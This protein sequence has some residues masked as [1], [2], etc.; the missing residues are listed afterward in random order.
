MPGYTYDDLRI[1]YCRTLVFEMSQDYDP[2]GTDGTYTHFVIKVRGFLSYG[3][4]PTADSAV[5]VSQIKS[6]LEA[7]RRPFT[8]RI[9]STVVVSVPNPPDAKLGPKP[10]PATVTAVNSGLFYV[11]C[12]CEVWQVGCDN[13]CDTRDPVVSLRWTQTESFDQN[14]YS[15][16]RT[17]GLLIVRADLRQCA[18]NFRPLA[19]PP[20]LPDYQR[21][22]SE[23]TLSPDGL[24]LEFSFDDQEVDRLPPDLATKAQGQYSVELIRPGYRRIGT[25][26]ISLE[27]PK[28]TSRKDLL[29]RA[30]LMA[31]T[32]LAQDKP[33][34]D[35]NAMWWGRFDEDL[36]S[37]KVRVSVSANMTPLNT[38]AT[39]VEAL[40]SV[41]PSVGVESNDLKSNKRGITPPER[42]RLARLLAAAFRDPC[43]C[44][45]AEVSLVSTGSPGAGA[46]NP[47]IVDPEPAGSAEL[48]TGTGFSLTAGVIDAA[49]S[50]VQGVIDTA[51]YD[52]MSIE[53]TTVL[54]TGDVMMP[55]TG[56]GPNADVAKPVKVAGAMSRMLV[57]W[58]MGR[59]GKPPELPTFYPTDTNLVALTGSVVAKDVQPSPDG[60][61][62]IY[63]V[64]GY[65][66][67]GIRDP[68]K[69]QLA[70]PVAPMFGTAVQQGAE[71]A[72]AFWTNAP[73]WDQQQLVTQ[74]SQPLV[75]GGVT[76]GQEPQ[77]PADFDS[78]QST[79]LMNLAAGAQVAAAHPLGGGNLATFYFYFPPVNQ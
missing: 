58:V 71:L 13:E 36:Y 73:V 50:I 4:F 14:W 64:A 25:V 33:L 38:K 37:P 7:P 61:Q 17:K 63:M 28:G 70:A 43:A 45:E 76:P 54:E 79:Y 49:S 19:T 78:Q 74:G 60:T 9:G 26:T 53:T 56:V 2:S 29:T 15:R 6:R 23:Y 75:Q 12:G 35:K 72:T 5:I 10:L 65:Y 51:P 47:E 24:Q 41:M 31:L 55:G 69:H 62:L 39:N 66:V 59:T 46:G 32:K 68:S 20:V 44:L 16:L 30:V 1:E 42:K 52:T 8:Y 40:Q 3:G 34:T 22:S 67:L 77:A 48:R 27:G 21:L 57:S 11:E 18:D